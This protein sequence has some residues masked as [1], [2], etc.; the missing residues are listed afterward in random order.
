MTGPLLTCIGLI[1]DII[2]VCLLF[3]YG[4]PPHIAITKASYL[5]LGNPQEKTDKAKRYTRIS[6]AALVLLIVGFALQ[7][8]AAWFSSAIR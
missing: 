4:L 3:R 7:G 8:V 2:G 1:L 5:V 6:Y